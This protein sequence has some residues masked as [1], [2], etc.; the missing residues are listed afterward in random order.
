[1]AIDWTRVEGDL[2]ALIVRLQQEQQSEELARLA[3][4]N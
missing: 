2:D 4:E 1:M 3:R